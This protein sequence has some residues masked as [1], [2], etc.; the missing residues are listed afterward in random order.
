MDRRT[1]LQT[2]VSALS[3]S[4]VIA[5]C[6]GDSEP[7]AVGSSTHSRGE[8]DHERTDRI[9]ENDTDS[10]TDEWTMFEHVDDEA[11]ERVELL[12]IEPDAD[13]REV[14]DERD[15][16]GVHGIWFVNESN[17]TFEA[18][19]TVDRDD[20]TV[21]EGSMTI[22]GDSALE[23]ILAEEATYTTTVTSESAGSRTETTTTATPRPSCTVSRTILSFG[24]GGRV[25]THTESR[26]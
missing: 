6:L 18:T 3:I 22:P 1:Y 16:D 9:N 2:G 23:V 26:C 19:L 17:S 4:G 25:G 5:G 10:A 13:G 24:D 14:I 12:E 15:H 8:S 7:S 21:L 11:I 20:E